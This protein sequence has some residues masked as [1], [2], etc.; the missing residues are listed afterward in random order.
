MVV[1]G[2]GD[3]SN[4]ALRSQPQ[5]KTPLSPISLSLSARQT[6]PGEMKGLG[7]EDGWQP[8]AHVV[9]GSSYQYQICFF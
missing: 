8:G 4:L 5:R 9:P 3:K 1:G 7:G 6:P 2:W